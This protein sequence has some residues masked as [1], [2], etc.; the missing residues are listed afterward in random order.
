MKSKFALFGAMILSLI[1]AGSAFAGT[2]GPGK[3]TNT[4][5]S[6]TSV[7]SVRKA[8]PRKRKL[9][10]HRRIRRARKATRSKEAK[11]K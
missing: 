8:K 10:K 11:E 5:A 7:K 3:K 4:K 9:R 1:I 2:T 6:T